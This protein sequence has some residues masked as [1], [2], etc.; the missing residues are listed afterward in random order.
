MSIFEF[1]DDFE[2]IFACGTDTAES[3]TPRSHRHRGVRVIQFCKVMTSGKGINRF[4][5]IY[6][7]TVWGNTAIMQIQKSKGVF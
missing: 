6:I 1:G 2:E 5:N 3:Q 7:C 4:K